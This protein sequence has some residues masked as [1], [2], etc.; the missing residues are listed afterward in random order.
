MYFSTTP[1]YVTI[2]IKRSIVSEAGTCLPS[3]RSVSN[4]FNANILPECPE[5]HKILCQTL[6][7]KIFFFYQQQ[8]KLDIFKFLQ[9]TVVLWSDPNMLRLG[10]WIWIWNIGNNSGSG[11][12]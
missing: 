9:N 7:K 8:L 4:C 3:P 5:Q 10:G 2:K 12:R 11:V 1:A 6:T